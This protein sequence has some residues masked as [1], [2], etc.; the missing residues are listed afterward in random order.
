M[1]GT[2]NTGMMHVADFYVTYCM[3]GGGSE[4]ECKA[5]PS[6]AAAGL[7]PVDGLDLWPLLSGATGVSPRTEVAVDIKGDSLC[8]IQGQYKLLVG[9]QIIAGWEGPIYPNASSQQSDPSAHH[10]PCATGCLFDVLADPTEQSDIAAAHPGIVA[11]MRARLAALEPTFYS[12]NE[13]GTDSPLCA[14]KPAKMPCACFLAMP[15][16]FWNGFFGPYQV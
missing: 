10:L 9:N 16:N 1:R 8:L 5:D 4:E 6:A 15:G 11:A 2:V 12:N 13:T 3:L 14:G 7:P